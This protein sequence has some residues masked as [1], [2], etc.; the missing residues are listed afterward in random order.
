MP[1]KEGSS[2][3]VKSTNIRELLHSF[4]QTGR[5]GNSKPSSM[6]KAVSQAVAIA[7][8]KARATI[9]GKG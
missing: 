9:A 2:N 6:K 8:R 5:I 3:K 4:K 7:Y 1:L